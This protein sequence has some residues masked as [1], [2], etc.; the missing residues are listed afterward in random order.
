MNVALRWADNGNTR[1][2]N[3]DSPSDTRR[4]QPGRAG[5]QE[6]AECVDTCS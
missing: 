5:T 2:S 6:A 3:T 4:G 1:A